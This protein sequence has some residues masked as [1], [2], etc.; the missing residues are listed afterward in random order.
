MA[1]L[2]A[3]ACVAIKPPVISAKLTAAAAL[4][5]GLNPE[6]N[7]IKL[8]QFVANAT[9]PRVV[10]PSAPLMQL[11]AMLALAPGVFTLD[12]IPKLQAE[13]QV[14]ANSLNGAVTPGMKAALQMNLAP[15]MKLSIAARLMLTLKAAG[16]DPMAENFNA[17]MAETVARMGQIVP[18]K[19]ALIKPKLPALASLAALPQLLKMTEVMKIPIG[20]P[21]GAQAALARLNLIAKLTPPKLAMSL[22]ATLKIAAI[23]SALEAI[24]AAFGADAMTPAGQARISFMMSAFAK[25]SMAIPLPPIDIGKID[26]LPKLENVILGEQIAGS[27][28]MAMGITGLK[29]PKLTIM[30]MLSATIA[31]RASLAAAIKVPPLT[32]CTNCGM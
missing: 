32:F 10:M 23:V 13:L 19:L 6:R 5:V 27:S 9:L 3:S 26:L 24:V 7:D 25:L 22:S 4:V 16:I 31:M 21:M 18:P 30:P 28:F 1:T 20:D 11:S 17:K 29:P 8:G 12:N 15:L 14:A 2:R